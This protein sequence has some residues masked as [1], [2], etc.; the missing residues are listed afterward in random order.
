MKPFKMIPLKVNTGFP[1]KFGVQLYG[2]LEFFG[3]CRYGEM[4]IIREI[5]NLRKRMWRKSC[6][7]GFILKGS[8]SKGQFLKAQI[9]TWMYNKLQILMRNSRQHFRLCWYIQMRKSKFPILLQ[10][11]RIFLYIGWIEIQIFY[12]CWIWIVIVISYSLGNVTT[13]KSEKTFPFLSDSISTP[14]VAVEQA[15]KKTS[16]IFSKS[17]ILMWRLQW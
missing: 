10:T 3:N 7:K 6:I 4:K 15:R 13:E 5:I 9:L 17:T 11:Q 8:D 14:E 2:I 16:P 12:G 1:N